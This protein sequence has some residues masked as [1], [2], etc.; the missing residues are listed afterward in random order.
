MSKKTNALEAA[1]R[2]AFESLDDALFAAVEA[3]A[4]DW[5]GKE[6]AAWNCIGAYPWLSGTNASAAYSMALQRKRDT[7]AEPLWQAYERALVAFIC[8]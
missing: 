3:S 1:L 8:A 2:A 7:A 6:G 4:D 5:L